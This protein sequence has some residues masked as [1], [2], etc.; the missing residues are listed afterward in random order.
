MSEELKGLIE[1]LSLALG[2][3]IQESDHIRGL[4]RRI[5]DGGTDANLTLAVILGLR[6]KNTEIQQVVFGP[7]KNKG[8]R[9]N[10]RRISAFDKRFLRALRIELPE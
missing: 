9:T 5:E 6:N 3:I 7:E 4:I 1:Q 8:K 10:L 2:N